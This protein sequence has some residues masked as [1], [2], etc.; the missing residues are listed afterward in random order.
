MQA[1]TW[2]RLLAE[3]PA[4][5]RG[6]VLWQ[7]FFRH[8]P[9]RRARAHGGP[10]VPTARTF[11]QPLARHCGCHP[12]TPAPRAATHLTQRQEVRP[13]GV[14]LLCGVSPV[15]AVHVLAQLEVAPLCVGH[16]LCWEGDTADSVW[17]LQ[18]RRPTG[19]GVRL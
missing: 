6:E 12:R 2:G 3:L 17:L 1:A 13:L 16:T 11:D 10:L 19:E 18:A 8:H 5:L 9:V 7:V 4:P 14:Q 15:D